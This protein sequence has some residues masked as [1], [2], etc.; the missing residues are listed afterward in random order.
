[1]ASSTAHFFS[2]SSSSSYTYARPVRPS[3]KESATASQTSTKAS[4]MPAE[5]TSCPRHK[6]PGNPYPIRGAV[7]AG[8]Y[9]DIKSVVVRS[10][11]WSC[12]PLGNRRN[13]A[14]LV[15]K[16]Y[17]ASFGV[18]TVVLIGRSRWYIYHGPHVTLCWSCLLVSCGGV[19]RV[20][21]VK[22]LDRIWCFPLRMLKRSS[23][24]ACTTS[25]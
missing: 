11:S 7:G 8:I 23:F 15:K 13:A 16:L 3:D 5:S 20:L 2:P 17:I 12:S 21:L 25:L 22:L 1:M 10:S 14:D 4:N 19:V 9:K 18:I 6:P 24:T